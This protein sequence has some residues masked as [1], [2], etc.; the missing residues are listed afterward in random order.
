[1]ALENRSVFLEHLID[2]QFDVRQREG[3]VRKQQDGATD[4]R[5]VHRGNLGVP[6]VVA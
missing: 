6:L 1:M 2:T 5:P 4:S 3:E